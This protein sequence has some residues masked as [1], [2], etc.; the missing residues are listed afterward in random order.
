M[1]RALLGTGAVAFAGSVGF[2]QPASRWLLLVA[3]IAAVLVFYI[4][5]QSALDRFDR[6][7]NEGTTWG[8]KRDARRRNASLRWR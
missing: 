2:P 3:L 1:I 4:V 8:R 6:W 7:V 5:V